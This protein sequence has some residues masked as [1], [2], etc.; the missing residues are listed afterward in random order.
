MRRSVVMAAVAGFVLGSAIARVREGDRSTSEGTNVAPVD[1]GIVLLELFAAVATLLAAYQDAVA[2]EGY[3][4]TSSNRRHP[5]R[6][7]RI[8]Q[9]RWASATDA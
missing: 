6:G 1:L 3:L 2:N 7:S 4:G 5:V 8:A 9:D